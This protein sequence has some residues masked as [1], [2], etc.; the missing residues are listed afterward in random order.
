MYQFQSDYFATRGAAHAFTQ[1]AAA[2]LLI[3]SAITSPLPGSEKVSPT[4]NSHSSTRRA[5]CRD[6]Q[7]ET[8][9][10]VSAKRGGCTTRILLPVDQ[11]TPAAPILLCCPRVRNNRQRNSVMLTAAI[12]IGRPSHYPGGMRRNI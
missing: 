4:A 5:L 10:A 8:R 11:Y 6:F 2:Q 9:Y 1:M 12:G 7:R 3:S